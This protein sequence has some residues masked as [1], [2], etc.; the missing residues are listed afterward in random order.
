MM[1]EPVAVEGDDSM[2]RRVAVIHEIAAQRMAFD[3]DFTWVK[4]RPAEFD[5]MIATMRRL[6]EERNSARD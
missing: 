1:A 6:T 3:G 4:L 2:I 5:W